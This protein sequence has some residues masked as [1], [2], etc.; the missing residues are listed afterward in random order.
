[1]G[2][3]LGYTVRMVRRHVR[4][5]TVSAIKRLGVVSYDWEWNEGAPL[6][7]LPRLLER[8]GWRRWL[9]DVVG[10]DELYDVV[11]VFILRAGTAAHMVPIGRLN[12]LEVL[13]LNC[14]SVTDGGLAHLEGL[15]SLEFLSL[16]GTKITD[17]ALV[18]LKGLTNL[19]RLN[20]INTKVTDA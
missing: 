16:G 1:I 18:H 8:P 17:A 4:N 2:V 13:Y 9:A 5:E 12:E 10:E 14:T 11:F 19:R 7:R 20:L 6:P 3:G 15:K